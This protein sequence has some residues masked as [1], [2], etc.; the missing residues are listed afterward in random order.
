[1]GPYGHMYGLGK[2]PQTPLICTATWRHSFGLIDCS[3]PLAPKLS[4]HCTSLATGEMQSCRDH[5]GVEKMLLFLFCFDICF[6]EFMVRLRCPN[7]RLWILT[8][9]IHNWSPRHTGVASQPSCMRRL[10]FVHDCPGFGI[11]MPNGGLLA[12]AMM[13]TSDRDA[14]ILILSWQIRQRM[15]LKKNSLVFLLDI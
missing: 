5:V 15:R 1:M 9:R 7:C 13:K 4:P 2:K 10:Q 3:L 8:A 6:V 11:S 14:P 12:R